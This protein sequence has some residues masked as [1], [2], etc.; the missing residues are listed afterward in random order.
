MIGDELIPAERAAI[1]VLDRGFL[2][3]DGVYEII[4]SFNGRLFR[5][6]DHLERLQAS[7]DYVQIVLPMSTDEL[8]SRTEV[9]MRA[10]AEIVSTNP[11]CRVGHWVSRGLEDWSRIYERTQDATL[12]SLVCPVRNHL[13]KADYENGLL[14]TLVSTRRNSPAVLDP[15]AKTTSKMNLILADV[16]AGFSRSLPLMLDQRGFIAESSTS[17]IFMVK[18]GRVLTPQAE[19]VLGGVTRKVVIELALDAG[20][21]LSEEDLTVV[22]AS[23]ADE[24]F[25]TSSTWGVVPVRAID[26]IKPR[27]GTNGPVVRLLIDKLATV[28]G[29]HPMDPAH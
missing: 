18:D 6:S 5:L 26:Q 11:V 22:D 9:L 20:F 24:I 10:N 15:R 27:L 12:V 7:L 19:W 16:E 17:N 13:T 14:M 4:P 8:A 21:E 3:G 29:F 25:L 2:W 28:T 1:S 23:S